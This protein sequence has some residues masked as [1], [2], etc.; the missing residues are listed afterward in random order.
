MT[1]SGS[2]HQ[3][4][5][6]INI[7]FLLSN[8]FLRFRINCDGLR[9]MIRAKRWQRVSG[10]VVASPIN[11][12]ARLH[13]E[14][15]GR[16]KLLQTL[17]FQYEVALSES[18]PLCGGLDVACLAVVLIPLCVAV[19]WFHHP[20]HFC[21]P[22]LFANLLP[23]SCAVTGDLLRIFFMLRWHLMADRCVVYYQSKKNSRRNQLEVFKQS[24]MILNVDRIFLKTFAALGVV[25]PY[26]MTGPIC[27]QRTQYV[28]LRWCAHKSIAVVEW[29]CESNIPRTQIGAKFSSRRWWEWDGRTRLQ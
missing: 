29:M 26:L 8:S 18:F 3:G 12:P 28:P 22:N 11:M 2:L 6:P 10:L 7:N 17:P 27:I 1:P 25:E 15:C 14:P 20:V 23:R 9:G 5:F 21:F 24:D 16:V 4:P 19:L 13:R